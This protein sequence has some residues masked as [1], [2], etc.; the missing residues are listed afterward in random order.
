VACFCELGNEC[1]NI[2]VYLLKAKNVEPGKEPLL[3]NGYVTRNNGVTVLYGSCRGC[4]TRSSCHYGSLETAV[5]MVGCWD[6]MA[7]AC[8]DVSAEAEER[9]L[10]GAATKQSSEDGD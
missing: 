8:E 6:E 5:R 4:I 2:V 9:Q 7:P 10:F 1:I 3:G